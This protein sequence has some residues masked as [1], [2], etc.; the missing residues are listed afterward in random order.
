MNQYQE[1]YDRLSPDQQYRHD[2]SLALRSCLSWR[3]MLRQ[4]FVPD[5]SREHLRERQKRLLEL[6]ILR[7]TGIEPGHA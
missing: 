5:L 2:R 4:D 3:R 6:R 7:A 1:W